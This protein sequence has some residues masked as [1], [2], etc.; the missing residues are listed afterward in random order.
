ML[1]FFQM[2]NVE[3]ERWA[4][5]PTMKVIHE[6][7]FHLEKSGIKDKNN[8]RCIDENVTQAHMQTTNLQMNAEEY[9]IKEQVKS[10]C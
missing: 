1:L 4:E 7:C 3:G 2:H 8:F 5:M 9:R 6:A 10:S